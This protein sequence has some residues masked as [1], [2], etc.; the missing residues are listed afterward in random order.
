MWSL[1][2]LKAKQEMKQPER[3]QD[4]KTRRRLLKVETGTNPG[5]L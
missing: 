1:N 4:K 2:S 5:Q 3:L